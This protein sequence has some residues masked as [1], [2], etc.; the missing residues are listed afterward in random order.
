[1][2]LNLSVPAL[3][4][5]LT[6]EIE[7]RPAKVEK[8]LQGLPLLNIADSGRQLHN[9]ISAYNRLAIEPR[10]RLELLE[11]YRYPI[12]QIAHELQKRYL[13]LPLPLSDKAKTTAE[14]NRELHAEMAYGYKHLALTA[15][16]VDPAAL[17][18]AARAEYALPIQRAISYLTDVLAITYT[19]YAPYPSGTWTEIHALYRCA[20]HL[21]IADIEI[22]DPLNATRPA[23]SIAAAYKHALLL[24]LSDPYHLPARLTARCHQYLDRYASS[25]QLLPVPAARFD[26]TCQFLIDQ[27]SDR[28]GV[29]YSNDT[30]VD[31]RE[32]HRLLNTIELARVIHAHLSVL[33][34]G[35]APE[36]DGL[37]RDFYTEGAHELLRRLILSWGVN[38]KRTFRRSAGD[39]ARVDVAIG[40]PACHWWFNGGQGFVRSSNFVGPMPQ[41]VRIEAQQTAAAQVKPEF[42]PEA[43]QLHDESAG[44]MALA[45]TG[46]IR[47]PVRVGDLIACRFA[48]EHEWM[49]AAVRWVKSANPST[50]EI[51][52]ERLAPSARPTVIAFTTDESSESGFLPALLLP[53]FPALKQSETVLVQ[54]GVYRPGRIVYI[55]DGCRLYPVRATQLV[56]ITG[57]F[58]RFQYEIPTA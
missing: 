9:N 34:Q 44:G 11:L 10:V 46:L 18:P 21:G 51:G 43:W 14:A 27:E 7:L 17:K 40:L 39:N 53:K 15:G 50:V 38:P 55:D 23:S 20:E 41:R 12:R 4:A 22:P 48:N 29:A 26:T 57:A 52:T 8:W 6:A 25:A 16:D 37:P 32:A 3:S 13:G 35:G 31:R 36:S 19:A 33:Q 28:A 5:R 45:K 42:A 1:M 47:A 54:R 24:D 56:E 58:E 2:G 30:E 49:I